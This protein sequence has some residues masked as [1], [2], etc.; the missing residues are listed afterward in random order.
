MPV[1]ARVLGIR[2]D[3]VH[4]FGDDGSS[5]PPTRPSSAST[6]TPRAWAYSTTRF[7]MSMF[8]SNGWCEASIITLVNRRQ[9]RLAKFE[10]F[11]VIEVEGHRDRDFTI[12]QD[13]LD[14]M[15][16]TWKPPMYLAAP[17]LPR[18]DGA[19]RA[20]HSSRM[21]KVH[22]RLLMLKFRR[23]IAPDGL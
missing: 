11:A 13:A 17:E 18:D 23:R 12:E 19:W 9:W 5:W 10:A 7:V 22:S 2:L 21:A 15:T 6:E 20:W 14:H 8:S 1:L 16:M 4:R 3:G